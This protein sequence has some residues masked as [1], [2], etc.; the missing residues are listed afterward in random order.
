M[1]NILLIDDDALFSDLIRRTLTND[2]NVVVANDV[3]QAMTQIDQQ[4]P[5]LI[6][7]D[8]LM[9]ASNGL[10]LLNELMSFQDTAAVPVII[11]SSVANELNQEALALAGVVKVLDKTTMQPTDVLHYARHILYDKPEV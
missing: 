10:N 8:V 6:V 7:L 2:F 1:K 3:Y 5:D 11:C 4:V 9:P